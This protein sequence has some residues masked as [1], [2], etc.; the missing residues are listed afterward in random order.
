MN[1]VRVDDELILKP[2]DKDEN[3]TVVK[4]PKRVVTE[5]MST[6]FE[7]DDDDDGPALKFYEQWAG[8]CGDKLKAKYAGNINNEES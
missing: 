7:C 5:F 4:G 8:R 3:G 1:Y 2:P 6:K